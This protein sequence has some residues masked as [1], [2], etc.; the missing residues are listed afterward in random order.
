MQYT[1][2][3]FSHLLCQF[4]IAAALS[5]EDLAERAGLSRR[6]VS[7]LER[8]LSRAPR[9]ETVRMLADALALGDEDRAALS[10]SARP[11]LL[12]H[13]P[14]VAAPAGSVSLPRPL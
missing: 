7:D 10:S 5:Q 8:G 2:S 13:G 11:H 14:P 9:L 12:G 6:C 3:T 4:R 1:R